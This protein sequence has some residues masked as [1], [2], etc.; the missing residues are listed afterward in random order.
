MTR[1]TTIGILAGLFVALVV[2]GSFLGLAL[3]VQ[4]GL[5]PYDA[6]HGLMSVLSPIALT[7]VILG[8]V[9]IIIIGRAVRIQGPG[10]WIGA[11]IIGVPLLAVIWFLCVA[12]LSGTLGNPF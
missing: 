11:M 9:G 1:R 4:G 12:T 3:L 2:P 10:A 7:E 8:P 6:A 5:A